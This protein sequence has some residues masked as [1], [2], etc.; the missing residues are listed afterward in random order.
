MNFIKDILT[1]KKQF[2]LTEVIGNNSR[3][4]VVSLFLAILEL[5]RLKEIGFQ[6][7]NNFSDIII[8]RLD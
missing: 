2:Q 7:T 1:N 8:I 3:I 6:Q 5:I 4:Y